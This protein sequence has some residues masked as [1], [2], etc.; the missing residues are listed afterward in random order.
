MPH[1]IDA[2]A[3]SRAGSSWSAPGPAG[4]KPPAWR[5]SAATT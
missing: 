1:V 3:D 4:S 5:A 2:G